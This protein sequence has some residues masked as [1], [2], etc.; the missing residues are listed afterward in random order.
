[1][2]QRGKFLF[3]IREW[4]KEQMRDIQGDQGRHGAGDDQYIALT[5]LNTD[6]HVVLIEVYIAAA[7]RTPLGG[8]NGSLASLTATKLGSIAIE[9]KTNWLFDINDKFKQFFVVVV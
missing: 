4:G 9:G 3:F 2:T 8:F 1:M 6:W 5:V 7:V